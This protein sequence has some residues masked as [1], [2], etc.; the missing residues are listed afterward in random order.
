[1]AL[2]LAPALIFGKP[3]KKGR[4]KLKVEVE[5]L[6]IRRVPEDKTIA[7]EGRIRN[8]G[9]HPI[10]RSFVIFRVL[11]P[12]GEEV[13]KQRGPIEEDPLGP[14]EVYEFHWQMKDLA[15]GVEVRVEVQDRNYREVKVD[16]PGPYPI[17]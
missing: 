5:Q 4:P 1:M 3:E 8:A 17:E 2:F 7:I 6:Q 13:S 14:G 16:K 15:R 10:S 9:E 12:D 11:A